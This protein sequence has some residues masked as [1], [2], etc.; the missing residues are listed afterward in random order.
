MG[1]ITIGIDPGKT[2]AAALTHG[3]KYVEVIDYTD[4]PTVAAGITNW[5]ML[6]TPDIVVLERVGA[7]PG[8]GVSST[9][10][11]GA[12]YGWWRGLLDAL[13]LPYIE[14]RPNDWMRS[15]RIP[16]KKRPSDKPSLPVARRMYPSAPLHLA[17]HH[18][19]ADA[20]L[21][22]FYGYQFLA[23]SSAHQST[24]KKIKSSV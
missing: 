6:V 23:G 9:F 1:I 19:R 22:A 4:G 12:N 24:P 16:K 14:R 17:K 7:M 5:L 13:Q 20:L 3:G 2:G 11:F 15:F 10:K 18:G 21:I 8:Q